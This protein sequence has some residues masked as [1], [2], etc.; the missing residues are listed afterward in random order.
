MRSGI[1]E[2]SGLNHQGAEC[3]GICLNA[4]GNGATP[5]IVDSA[6]T[7][8]LQRC[9]SSSRVTEQHEMCCMGFAASTLNS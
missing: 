2:R 9:R 5:V 7:Q 3:V 6:Y 1:D 8:F 4:C